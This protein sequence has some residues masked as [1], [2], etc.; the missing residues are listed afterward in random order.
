LVCAVQYLFKNAI[1]ISQNFIVPKPQNEIAT[2]FQIL[3]PARVLLPLLKVLATVELDDQLCDWTAKIHDETV[4]RHL[5]P[6]FQAAKTI[7][8]Q[9]EPKISFSIGL[10][11]AQLTYHFDS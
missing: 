9:L 10:L 2:V 5:T 8:A 11:P 4:Q 6:E 7:V 3:G 1:D